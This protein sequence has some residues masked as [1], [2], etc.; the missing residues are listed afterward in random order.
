MTPK[1]NRYNSGWRMENGFKIDHPDFKK[2][3]YSRQEAEEAKRK[4]VK[5]AEESLDY[6]VQ[7]GDKSYEKMARDWIKQYKSAAILEVM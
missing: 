5:G 3:Y 4:A 6:A 7:K 2:T 1:P